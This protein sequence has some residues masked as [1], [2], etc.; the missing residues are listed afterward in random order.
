MSGLVAYLLSLD[1]KG[2]FSS[3]SGA[4]VAKMTSDLV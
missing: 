1:P 3:Q 2:K 4:S